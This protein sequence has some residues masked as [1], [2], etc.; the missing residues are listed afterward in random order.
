VSAEFKLTDAQRDIL[1][2]LGELMG[3]RSTVAEVFAAFAARVLEA[4]AFDYTTLLVTESDARFARAV[5]SYPFPLGRE[6]G[7]GRV[8]SKAAGFDLLADSPR[9]AEYDPASIG[10]GPVGTLAEYG[11]HRAWS[12]ALV[13]DGVIYGSF[14][15]ARRSPERFSPV[16]RG[17]LRA[18]T[19]IMA[20]A[21]RQD[22]QVA[23]LERQAA[24][25]GLLNQLA[26]L[27]YGGEPMEVI[28]DPFA[29]LMRR[30]IDCDSIL[31][32]IAD[33]EGML[34]VAGSPGLPSQTGRALR[35]R[36]GPAQGG[37]CRGAASRRVSHRVGLQPLGR[38]DGR[39][40]IAARRGFHPP[41]QR[42]DGWPGV[43]RP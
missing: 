20:A 2:D 42:R 38:R 28:F 13:V 29:E 18:A 12:G 34:R 7:D 23:K 33:S 41:G 40:R 39:P 1:L 19:A 17:F 11:Y 30:A 43:H 10:L 9:G 31:L 8:S 3:Q 32:A 5:G 22:A 6:L 24:R 27:L 37:A 15:V 14:T 36:G 25:S 4:A 21:V 16:D 35:L 26:F